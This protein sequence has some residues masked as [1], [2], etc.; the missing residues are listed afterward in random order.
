LP[1]VHEAAAQR[2]PPPAPKVQAGVAALSLVFGTVALVVGLQVRPLET[3][4]VVRAVAEAL[5]VVVPVFVG[6]YAIRREQTAR[7][8]RL[9]LIAG[10]AWAPSTLA[11]SSN[12]VAY[13]IGRI[14][15]WGVLAWI[16]YLLLAFPVGRVTT[17]ADRWLVGAGVVSV[18]LLYLPTALFAEFP[19]PSPW[20]SCGTHC[21]ANAFVVV[22]S[23]PAWV[24]TVERGRDLTASLLYVAA[25]T[26]VAFRWAR[27]S[28]VARRVLGP[29]FAFALVYLGA[30]AAFLAARRGAG[31]ARLT[32]ALGLLALIATPALTLA[33]LAGLMRWRITALHSWRRLAPEVHGPRA[34]GGVR[35]V[36]AEAIRDPSLEIGYWYGDHARWVNEQGLPFALPPAGSVRALTEVAA[37]GELVA[38]LVHDNS[39]L[40]EPAIREVIQGVA[41]MALV[42]QQVEAEAQARLRELSES[43]ARIIEAI[44]KDRLRIERDLHDGAQQRLIALKVAA[45]RGAG[46]AGAQANGTGELFRRIAAEA[47]AALDDVRAL[48]RGVYPPLLRDHGLVE[49]LRDAVSR[50]G[51]W[52]DV[53]ARNVGRYPQEIE[54]AVYFSCLEA[55]QNAE[56]HASARSVSINLRAGGDVVFEVR[57]DGSGFEIDQVREGTGL[58]N[59]RDRVAALGGSLTVESVVGEGT[60]VAGRV[61]I[62]PDHVPVEI[63]RFVLRATDALEDAL[64]IYRAV[65]TAR[66]TIVDFAVEHVNDAACTLSGMTRDAQVGKTLGQLRRD[67]VRSPLFDWH[68]KALESAEPMLREDVEYVGPPG[69]RRIHAAY[70]TRAVALGG[71]RLAI[72]WRDTTGPKRAQIDLELRAD[73]LAGEGAAVCV[74][75]ASTRAILYANREFERMLGYARGELEGR[76]ATDFDADLPAPERFVPRTRS[77]DDVLE[78]RLR[79]SDG[80]IICCELT[81][82]GFD[83]PDLGWCWVA[84]HRDV[85]ALKEHQAAVEWQRDHLQRALRGLPALA[86]STDRDLKPTVL[87]D[88]LVRPDGG[89]RRSGSDE[90]LFGTALAREVGQLNRR[91]RTPASTLGAGGTRVTTVSASQSCRPRRRS[92]SR[93]GTNPA[94]RGSAASAVPPTRRR[95]RAART[96]PPSGRVTRMLMTRSPGVWPVV[97]QK[98]AA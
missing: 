16:I 27:G 49:A 67:Y 9:L 5:A 62:R 96:R 55:V 26:R 18:A 76:P 68:C 94:S 31:D 43:R 85:T 37:Q 17:R 45:D 39:N 36:I 83:H 53:R 66:G 29:V 13:S 47:T 15:A 73:A 54:A 21:P 72:L 33:F 98:A 91:E 70:E 20:S 38:I 87:F 1:N 22:D 74:V 84:V 46:G 3:A 92:F 51:L 58:T 44:D 2:V 35:D 41:M 25:A 89:E 64:A 59:M 97:V 81:L 60:L 19:V 77:D 4:D 14:W 11:M 90:E 75:R 69:S 50:S 79:R 32:E 28:R 71:G 6:L 86:Y 61:P 40:A 42:N 95:A 56:K 8:A 24:S 34:A 80:S 78:V 88:S 48:A 23:K 63:E 93:I 12:S 7:F 82:D 65:R 52:A 30:A 10:L 57:D